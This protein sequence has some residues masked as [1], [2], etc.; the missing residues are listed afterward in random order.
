MISL[1]G[2]KSCKETEENETNLPYLFRPVGIK[3]DIKKTNVKI[4]WY[5]VA[6]AKGYNIQIST[7]SLLFENLVV[8]DTVLT[9]SYEV[10]LGGGLTYSLRIKAIGESSDKDSK[11][12]VYGLFTTGTENLFE[13]YNQVM[14][15]FGTFSIKWAPNSSVTNIV[16]KSEGQQDKVIEISAEEAQSGTKTVSNLTN[17][18]YTIEIYN[19]QFKRGSVT[20]KVEGDYVMN[21]GDTLSKAISA[22]KDGGTIL[23]KP[24]NYNV[25]SAA[26]SISKSIKIKG[27]NPD[28]LPV[29]YMDA[30]ASNT[31]NM[32]TIATTSRLNY[33]IFENIS[34]NGYRGL[35]PSG[36]IG[37]IFNQGS[38]CN[39][40]KIMFDNCIIQHVGRTPLRVKDPGNKVIDTVIFNKCLIF[41]IGNESTY[42]IINNNITG[43]FI[44][45][46]FITN[47]TFNNFAGSIILHNSNN[48]KSVLIENCTFND[49]STS[50][51]SGTSIRYIVD[52]NTYI[53][54][55]TL[56]VNNC[57]FGRT[58]RQ[59]TEG[60]RTGA[61]TALT[62][63][64]SYCTSDYKDNNSPTITYSIIGYLNA[65]S[66][67]YSDLWVDPNNNDFHFKDK[68]FAGKSSTGD[69]RWR[70]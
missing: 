36:M 60:I 11:F 62:I 15:S 33:I 29:F 67:T 64:G 5:E 43:G 10:E 38:E 65:Y 35:D 61:G 55:N 27:F 69:P 34:F 66:G 1:F 51:A 26:L 20:V 28:S 31:T 18:T 68:S 53:V 8:N 47:S 23:V 50:G 70:E 3:L 56:N 49:I 32:L 22:I 4:S 14:T 9:T 2:V 42:A 24:G 45:N 7:D 59:Y 58:P 37:Y 12:N 39:V 6:N 54:E 48:S 41:D 25:G 16:I 19:N 44:N 17:G 46:I 63:K 57:I 40:G 13:G 21:P 52:Y 30:A